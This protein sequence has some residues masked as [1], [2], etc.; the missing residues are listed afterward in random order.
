MALS[1]D[2]RALLR[3]LLAGD[4]YEQV[5]EVMGTSM[6]EVR[7]KAREAAAALEMEPDRELP[8]EVV[9]ERLADLE[10]PGGPR[11]T[12]VSTPATSAAPAR[13]WALWIAGAVAVAIA[14]VVVV[15]ARSGGGGNDSGASNSSS[16]EEAVPIRL[17]P[18][19]GS[20]ASGGVTL[21]RIGDQPALDLDIRGLTPSGPGRSYVLWFVGAGGRSLPVAF[22]AVGPD[23]TLMGR[24]AIPS[25]AT[26]LLPSFQI[27]EL[28]L[29]R[30]RQAAAAVEQ[31]A[32][33]GTLP[34]P[35]GTPVM[36]G[37][38]RG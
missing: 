14:L 10:R 8:S 36:R 29:V 24:T 17:T 30:Q 19:G 22:R 28:N 9:A 25:A 21:I 37:A 33:S 15:I 3:L 34:E 12:S 16:Q 32:R 31:A 4:T 26:G 11:S 27:A 20:K 1:D 13:R 23:G 6:D 35:I 38:L 18:V 5:A 2:Q 7:T